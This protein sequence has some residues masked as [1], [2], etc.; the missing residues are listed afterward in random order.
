MIDQELKA[1]LD[2]IPRLRCKQLLGV[3]VV[4][5]RSLF[6]T[7]K[8]FY[9]GGS[10]S[11]FFFTSRSTKLMPVG[12]GSAGLAGLVEGNWPFTTASTSRAVPSDLP[13]KKTSTR[14]GS[15]GSKR[16]S[17]VSPARWGGAS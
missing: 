4:A 14:A 7:K 15:R 3:G 8:R 16:A 10:S 6:E 1:R 5:E 13:W 11:S 2:L 17:T 9:H 12:S